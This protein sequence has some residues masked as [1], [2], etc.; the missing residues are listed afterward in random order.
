MN[1]YASWVDDLERLQRQGRALPLGGLAPLPRTARRADAPVALIFAPHP[2]DE[3]LIGGLPLRL[4]REAGW[5]VVDVAVTQG[6][7]TARQAD[8]WSEL[9]ACCEYIGF[10]LVATAP[11]GLRQ[12]NLATRAADPSGWAVRVGRIAEILVEHAPQAV[13]FPHALD[14]NETHVGTHH[15]VV[16]ALTSLGDSFQTYTLETEL[17]ATSSAP[18]LMIELGARDLADLVAALSFHV[19]EVRRNPYHLTLPAQMVDNVRRGSELVLGQGQVAPD[20]LFAT[21]YRLRSWQA[22]NFAEVLDA[23]RVVSVRDD[24]A[25]VLAKRRAADSESEAD[26]GL[27]GGR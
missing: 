15:L 23:G 2:D 9:R 3:V 6:S 17:W 27:G 13:F 5:R 19:G 26:V 1:P 10:E 14:W 24:V 8:R 7:N 18:N 4:M 11:G 22:G 20:V 21:L 25:A 16:D 12:V